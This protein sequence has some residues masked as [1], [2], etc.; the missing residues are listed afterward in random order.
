MQDEIKLR[1]IRVVFGEL[2]MPL[3]LDMLK[4]MTQYLGSDGT[5]RIGTG[6]VQS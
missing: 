4:T 2:A 3:P 6:D 5:E 1:E